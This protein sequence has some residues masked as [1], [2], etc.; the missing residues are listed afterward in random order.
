MSKLQPPLG[1]GIVVAE[2]EALNG[3][4]FRRQVLVPEPITNGPIDK[5]GSLRE[6]RLAPLPPWPV[7][8]AA[9]RVPRSKCQARR[10][11]KLQFA[12]FLESRSIE[13]RIIFPSG[14]PLFRR[15]ADHFR[16]FGV[17]MQPG[18][19]RKRELLSQ[20]DRNSP[21][22]QPNARMRIA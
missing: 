6:F 15:K 4:D 9:G 20:I 14:F 3:L 10:S 8:P 18:Q 13:F 7:D 11:P 19:S 5:S 1:I 12:R 2:Q 17:F 22:A 21:R 16:H